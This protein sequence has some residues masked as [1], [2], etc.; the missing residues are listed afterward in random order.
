M[1]G[2]DLSVVLM[3]LEMP[4]TNGITCVRKIRRLGREGSIRGHAPIVAVTANVRS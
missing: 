1:A 2:E 3:D 4:A